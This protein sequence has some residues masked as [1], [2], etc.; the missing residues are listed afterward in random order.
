MDPGTPA[1]IVHMASDE[2]FGGTDRYTILELDVDFGTPANTT[3]TRTDLAADPYDQ[4]LCG[5]APN[6]IPQPGTNVGLDAL[7]AF[8]L[9]QAPVRDLDPT[10]GVDLR[11]LA[12]GPVDVNGA[13]LSGIRWVEL[14]NTG[15]GW[16]VRQQSTFAPADGRHRWMG[17]IA[18]N[19]AGDI[20]MGGENPSTGGDSDWFL[21]RYCGD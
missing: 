14:Q 13:D 4:N 16:S 11:L 3:L 9:F 10:A 6:C 20:A 5:F 18:M 2:G 15:A 12:Q 7:A 17:S 1:P 21:I 19:G 8:T